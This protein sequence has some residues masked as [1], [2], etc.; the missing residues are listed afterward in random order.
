MMIGVLRADEQTTLVPSYAALFA[1]GCA[2][3][4]CT[5]GHRPD[6]GTAL[7]CALAEWMVAVQ[8]TEETI[9]GDMRQHSIH[10]ASDEAS[11]IA[12]SAV[13]FGEIN[14]SRSSL[15]RTFQTASK[16]RLRNMVASKPL[17]PLRSCKSHTTLRSESKAKITCILHSGLPTRITNH[18]WLHIVRRRGH[19]IV[20]ACIFVR[21]RSM[22]VVLPLRGLILCPTRTIPSAR[23]HGPQCDIM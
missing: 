8:R 21:W 16:E 4:V 7:C 11:S 15:S 9:A 18:Q 23:C 14:R 2:F 19:D 17:T 13:A 3:M 20:R 10:K 5:G 1:Y 22:S 12:K 6:P